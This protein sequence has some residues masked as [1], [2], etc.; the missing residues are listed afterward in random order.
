[1]SCSVEGGS[2]PIIFL[3]SVW[4]AMNWRM[5]ALLNMIITGTGPFAF[6][7]VTSVISTSTLIDG[8]AELSTCPTNCFSTTG[9]TPA[10]ESVVFFTA[11]VTLRALGGM[12]PT[13][14]RSKSSTISGRRRFHHCSADVTFCPLFNVSASGRSPYGFAFASR[15]EEHT[16]EL[17][18]PMYLVCRLLLEKKK[19]K[20]K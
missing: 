6:R 16:S 8:Y 20:I 3:N 17:Q 18:S 1:M 14:S 2:L 4:L 5:A 19:D 13:T 7:G 11:Q 10:F 12:R 15:S 9:K